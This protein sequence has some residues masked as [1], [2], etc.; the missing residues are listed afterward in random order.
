M[1][2]YVCCFIIQGSLVKALKS[3]DW[4]LLD[5]INLAAAETLQCLAGL[6]PHLGH[7]TEL[8]PVL[9][10][11]LLPVLLCPALVQQRSQQILTKQSHAVSQPNNGQTISSRLPSSSCV[12]H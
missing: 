3:G 7:R 8:L 1:S 11:L 6:A 10:P 2:K 12:Y 4:V 5:E 9:H